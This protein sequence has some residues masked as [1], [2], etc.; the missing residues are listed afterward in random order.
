MIDTSKLKQ[1]LRQF[2]CSEQFFRNPLFPQYVYTE[3]VQYLAQ[4]ANCYWL[5]DYI[6]SNQMDSKLKAESF[7]TWTIHVKEENTAIIQ[8][9]DGN[10]NTL[11]NFNLGYTDF[12]IDLCSKEGFTL[13]LID[14]TLL[15]PSEY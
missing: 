11:K 1:E 4:N 7:Q 10:K 15:L 3:G 6:F 13:W 14:Q 5:L 8:V 12:P 9:T 2:Y